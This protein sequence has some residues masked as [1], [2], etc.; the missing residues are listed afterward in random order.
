MFTS[1]AGRLTVIGMPESTAPDGMSL[2]ALATAARGLDELSCARIVG[3]AADAVHAAQKAGQVQAALSPTTIFVRPDGS[4]VLVGGPAAIAYTAPERLQG[5]AGDRRSDVFTLGAVLW[6]A[7]VRERLFD[8]PDDAAIERAVIEAQFVAPSELNANVPAELDAICK[9]ALAP[10]PADRYP[11]TKVMAAEI[12]A[13]LGEAGYPESNEHIAAAVA[14]VRGPAGRSATSQSGGTVSAASASSPIASASASA[15]ASASGSS[16]PHARTSP[17]PGAGAQP[18]RP[19]PPPLRER[20]GAQTFLGGHNPAEPV[21]LPPAAQPVVLGGPAPRTD[22]SQATASASKSVVKTEVFSLHLRPPAEPAPAAADKPGAATAFL[23]SNAM[24]ATS[25]ATPAVPGSHTIV[26][27][28]PATMPLREAP[29]YRSP[30]APPQAPSYAPPAMP[31]PLDPVTT[32]LVTGPPAMPPPI[33]L[34]SRPPGITITPAIPAAVLQSADDAFRDDH[35]ADPSQV[36]ARHFERASS[37]DLLGGWGWTTGS[38]A[39]VDDHDHHGEIARASRRRLVIAIGGAIG[40]VAAIVAAALAFGPSKPDAQPPALATALPPTAAPPVA[41]AALPPPAAPPAG[42][43]PAKP[44]AAAIAP[45]ANPAP[46][47]PASPEPAKPEPAKLV[48]APRPAEPKPAPRIDAKKPDAKASERAKRAQLARSSAKAAPI[49]PYGAPAGRGRPDPVASYR[50]G[51]QQYARGET[52]AALLTFRSSL[53]SSPNFAATW[54]G[55]GLVYE[56]LGNRS[57][58]RSAYRRYLQLAPTAPD[59]EQIRDRMER[60]GP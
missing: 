52:T 27:P 48:A 28:S 32:T 17:L 22:S 42:P 14:R 47:P 2:H 44:E 54:R 15:A 41:P 36:A 43:E 49:D 53:A 39:I 33:A 45:P 46:A 26:D 13:V 56:K 12:D 16:A 7:L 35:R 25:L 11:S 29:P 38:A 23:G 24:A 8:G 18:S 57:Q 6:E 1:D 59:G 21:L 20:A 55:L 3:N 50:T 58:A 40:V 19:L 60:L 51:L 5:G 37:R 31:A 9:K 10:D 30:T 4:V 34:L